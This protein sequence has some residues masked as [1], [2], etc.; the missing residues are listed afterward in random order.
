MVFL[1]NY[2]FFPMDYVKLVQKNCHE[3]IEDYQNLYSLHLPDILFLE[4]RLLRLVKNQE[5][6]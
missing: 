4:Q 2:H 1:Q 5:G 6:G 3:I